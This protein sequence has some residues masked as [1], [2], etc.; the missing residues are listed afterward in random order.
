MK[1]QIHI[2]ADKGINHAFLK[3]VKTWTNEVLEKAEATTGIHLMIW[4]SVEELRLFY[5]REK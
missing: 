4:R 5:E 3:R 1:S 2:A